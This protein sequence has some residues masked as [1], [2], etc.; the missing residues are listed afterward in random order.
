ME[1]MRVDAPFWQTSGWSLAIVMPVG[2]P[3]MVEMTM[4]TSLPSEVWRHLDTET[5]SVALP[6]MILRLEGLFGKMVVSFEG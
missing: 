1:S 2:L 5:T 3:P 4:S 6:S